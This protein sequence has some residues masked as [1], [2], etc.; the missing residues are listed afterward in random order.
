MKKII[1]FLI[2]VFFVFSAPSCEQEDYSDINITHDTEEKVSKEFVGDLDSQII[3]KDMDGALVNEIDMGKTFFV[4]DNTEGNSDTSEWVI[5]KGDETITSKEQI[6]RLNFS[7]PGVATVKL[8]STRSSDGKTTSSETTVTINSVPVKTRFITDPVADAETVAIY[9]SN[10]ISFTDTSE[11]SPT[12]FNWVFEGPETLTS[13]EQ[14]PVMTFMEPGIYNVSLTATRDDGEEGISEDTIEKIGFIKVE[15]LVVE[16]IRAVATDSKIELQ[17]TQPIAQDI[18]ATASS[19][20]SITI[21]TKNGAILTPDIVSIEATGEKTVELVFGDKMYSDDEVLI[22]FNP[23]GILKD[24]TG[25]Y[26][27]E[28]ITDEPCVYGHNLWSG[29]DTEDESKFALSTNSNGSGFFKFV[30]ENSPELPMEPY[31]GRSC[32]GFIRGDDKIGLSVMQGYTVAEGD[33]VVLAYEG[34]RIENVAGALERRMSATMASGGN[35]ANGNWSSANSN[36]GDNEWITVTK[37]INV[38]ADTKGVTGELFLTFFRYGGNSD[39][40]ALWIDNLRIYKPN[41]RP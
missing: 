40:A 10:S 3:I 8:T 34:K 13:T 4:I 20:F 37:T 41:P 15:Q 30:D 18:P 2:S 31:Q 32:I 9:T 33:V 25:N 1:Y 14:N 6:V 27:P 28:M 38:S 24:A 7:N 26:I 39:T 17:F 19:E 5:T 21:N 22:S 23:S 12:E 11:G 36:G 35:D 16:L 29:T